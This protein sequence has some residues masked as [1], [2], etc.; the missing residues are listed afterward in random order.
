M[1]PMSYRPSKPGL[2]YE[3]EIRMILFEN[4][5]EIFFKSRKY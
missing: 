5:S 4:K 3:E 2:K 1:L